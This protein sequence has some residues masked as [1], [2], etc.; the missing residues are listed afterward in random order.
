MYRHQVACAKFVTQL[1]KGREELGSDSG[2]TSF[3]FDR[4]ISTREDVYFFHEVNIEALIESAE[5]LKQH[6]EGEEHGEQGSSSSSSSSSSGRIHRCDIITKDCLA[7]GGINMRFQL[8]RRDRGWHYLHSRL[9]YYALLYLEQ[10]QPE[11]TEQQGKPLQR[12][13]RQLLQLRQQPRGGEGW[14]E[15][16]RSVRGPELFE[17]DQANHMGLSAC[18]VP[19]HDL[20]ATAVRH[21]KAGASCFIEIELWAAYNRHTCFPA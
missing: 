15:A 20:P 2:I 5:A 1:E 19:I 6:Q 13:R 16:G 7:W 14:D 21:T 9:N 17:A 12:R 8:L 18:A 10:K 3:S 11:S 4:L